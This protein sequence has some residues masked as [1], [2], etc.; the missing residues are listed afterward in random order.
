MMTFQKE[1]PA[2]TVKAT[3]DN[4][5]DSL[6]SGKAWASN[7]ISYSF[8]DNF[9]T[10]YEP[11]YVDSK[12]HKQ[13]FEGFNDAQK[14]ATR[15][16][17]R[18]FETVSNINLVELT[19]KQDREATIRIAESSAAGDTAYAHLP[20]DIF[21]FAAGDIWFNKKDYN[22]PVLGDFA[23]FQ[24]GH[25]LGH[26]L[27]LEHGHEANGV[28]NVKMNANR[29]SMEFSVMSY[30]SFINDDL[31][32]GG[33]TN[34]P[35]GFAQSLM[36]YDIRAI[37]EMY[38]VNFKTNAGDTRYTF[39]TTTGEMFVDGVGQGKPGDNRIFR[40]I[41]DG[42][43]NDTYDFSNYT[44]KV[45]VNLNPGSWSNLDSEG[46]RQ[47]AIL[48][49]RPGQIK[50][51]R[52]HVFNALQVQKADGTL[53]AR[54]LIENA[55]GGS[56]DDT[57]RGNVANNRLEGREGND[58]LFG[59]RGNDLLMGADG[60]DLLSGGDGADRLY[61]DNGQD[62]LHGGKGQDRL[63]GGKG[64]DTLYGDLGDDRLF[65]NLNNDRLYGGRG[66]DDLDGYGHQGGQEFDAL[67]GGAG[68]DT[69][70]LGKAGQGVSYLG[71]GYATI[72]DWE[73]GQDQVQALGDDDQY[74]LVKYDAGL[75]SSALDLG[76]YYQGSSTQS[77]D[78]I[79]I[80]QDTT[81][82]MIDGDFNFV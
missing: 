53:D 64:N 18:N 26:A 1:T 56:H 46:H 3:S 79:A 68:A 65:G 15:Y 48:D 61:A 29:D 34:E 24:I 31:K 30:R 43:G 5:I 60:N 39:S 50:Y 44:T 40:T 12:T 67:I 35:Y 13:S 11:G 70:V 77:S 10:D 14:S 75:G 51:A 21:K 17:I 62:R 6:L 80:F 59:L 41:W 76:L 69:F 63:Y 22:H 52:A 33:F 66:N 72:I 38:G 78:L 8:T 74:F 2:K 36:M 45:S 71:D 7:T 55:I 32:S 4:N 47:L 42:N 73:P 27:G 16:W 19:G 25:E 49:G 82:V 81:D 37:Q 54:S 57:I 28:R 23:F 58:Q 9:A 20:G